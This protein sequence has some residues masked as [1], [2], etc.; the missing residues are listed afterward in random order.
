MVNNEYRMSIFDVFKSSDLSDAV[1]GVRQFLCRFLMSALFQDRE[2][3]VL[4]RNSMALHQFRT[5]LWG[6]RPP[7]Q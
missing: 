4:G 5:F 2:P 7:N 1:F 6:H 3:P